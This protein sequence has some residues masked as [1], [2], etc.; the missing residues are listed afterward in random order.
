MASEAFLEALRL[1]KLVGELRSGL[2]PEWADRLVEAARV[3]GSVEAMPE[4]L[5]GWLLDPES[6]PED[7][8]L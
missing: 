4:P 8:R 2:D 3:A 7:A 5:K 6:V 1:D